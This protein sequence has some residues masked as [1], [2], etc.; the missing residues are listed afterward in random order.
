MLK[1]SSQD[2]DKIIPQEKLYSL[3][4]LKAPH[5][6]KI[7]AKWLFVLGIV[8]IIFLFLPW[9][10]N[11]RGTGKVTALN[12]MNRPQTI[13][14]VIAG[15]IRKWH[16]REGQFIKRGDT[17]V[18]ISEVKEKYFDPQ[19]LTRMREQ[20]SAKESSLLSK[21]QKAKA[22]KRQ[23]QAL[24]EGMKNK[25]EQ[26]QAK[27]EAEKFRFNNAEN[28][29]QRN[30]KLYE[31]GNIPLTKFQDIE[32]KFKGAQA[33]YTNAKIELDRVAA[34]Y[35]DK[36]SKAESDQSN[37]LAEIFDGQGEL[38]KYRNEYS[39]TE[40]RSNQYQ[41]LAPQDGTVVKAMKAGLGET[42]KEG[43][44]VCTIMPIVNDVAIELYVKA[45]DVPLLSKGR[46]VRIQF[47][48][49]PALQFSG[50]PSV[51]VGT[52][53]G[54]IEVID[55]VNSKPG[56]FRVLAIPDKKDQAWPKQLRNGSGIKGWVMLDDVPVWYEI[57]R[58]LNGFPP[59]LY[60][61]P[62]DEV[63]DK[64]AGKDSSTKKK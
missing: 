21:D 7:L 55:Y 18:T 2:I 63:V 11:I 54:T 61:E 43:D 14:A 24:K 27:L 60:E 52:F 50:W 40:I 15:Q 12:P 44:A 42:I 32:Y 25:I 51:S 35:L 64:K 46:K 41:I 47:D 10:Q 9:Q 4:A 58:Q 8:F 49:W 56:E 22:L 16:V 31:A 59:S 6:G 29:Y 37:T 57:W 13:E 28:Q 36:I 1:L 45:M 26:T 39:N 17:I 62:L 38:A 53:G 33:D 19:L 30:K 48:G 5:A 34:E 3:R 20:I 23:V